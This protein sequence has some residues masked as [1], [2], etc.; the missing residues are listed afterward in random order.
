MNAFLVTNIDKIII[1]DSDTFQRIGE[2]PIKLM[3]TVS[4]EPNEVIG[5][6]ASKDE[7]WLAIISG[8]NLVMNMQS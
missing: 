2:I 6:A 7:Q 3:P 8:K 5:M 1:Y 4:R